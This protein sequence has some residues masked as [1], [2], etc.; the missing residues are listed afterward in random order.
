MFN[1]LHGCAVNEVAGLC[2]NGE[3]IHEF[4]PLA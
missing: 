4:I 2:L 1:T 3:A